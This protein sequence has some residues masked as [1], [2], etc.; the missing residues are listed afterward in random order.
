[1]NV[2]KFNPFEVLERQ[3][4]DFNPFENILKDF[5]YTGHDYAVRQ[6]P[7]ANIIDNEKSVDIQILIPGFNKEDISI[8]IDNQ[9]LTVS[10]PSD[11]EKPADELKYIRKEFEFEGFERSFRLGRELNP[12]AITAKFENG[13]LNISIAKKEEAIP[14]PA[15]EIS[16]I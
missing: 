10:N 5:S 1:M 2:V 4:F 7:A 14:K 16:I 12:E 8:T 3:N 13:I 15:R 6:K 11:E 9:I